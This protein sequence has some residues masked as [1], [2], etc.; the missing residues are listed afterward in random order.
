M[1][2]LSHVSKQIWP[3]VLAVAHLK[4][5]R[6]LL[7]HSEDAAESKGLAQRLKRLFDDAGHHL[8]RAYSPQAAPET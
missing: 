8:S 4:P 7:L 3:Q 6:V 2:L 1:T 5:E